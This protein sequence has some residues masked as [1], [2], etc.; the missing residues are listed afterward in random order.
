MGQFIDLTGQRFGRWTVVDRAEDHFTKSGIRVTMWNCVCNCGT[1]K[2]VFANSLRKNQSTS[3]G[4]YEKELK[5][6][7]LAERNRKNAKHGHSKERLH[8][9][10]NGMISRCY[11]PNNCCFS[12]YGERG[13][14]VCDAWK[15][16]YMEFK[17]WA[18]ANGYD[19]HA[20][21]GDCTLDRVDNSKGYSPDNCRWATA[22]Q[23][24][25][26]RRSNVVVSAFGKTQNLKAWADETGI[27]YGTLRDRIVRRKWNVERAL[28][29][30][31]KGVSGL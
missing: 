17:N 27:K 11:N 2:S 9:I 1:Q 14:S 19:E 31:I 16:D 28:S 29:E 23:Q 25:N 22:E 12:M 5:S 26:N 4:C 6:K 21:Y 24:A 15:N 10:W 7:R 13:I 30:P 8:A 20:E 18:I 3:C